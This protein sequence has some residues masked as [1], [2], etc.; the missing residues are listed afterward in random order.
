MKRDAGDLAV[1][2]TTDLGHGLGHRL[3]HGVLELFRHRI[4]Q[5][6]TQLAWTDRP[7]VQFEACLDHWS[8]FP[9]PFGGRWAKAEAAAVFS[10]LLDFGFART[11][12]AAEAACGLVTR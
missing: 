4:L 6:T 3:L 10:A 11:F 12:E 9:R 1:R 2:A 7:A 8:Y 5:L